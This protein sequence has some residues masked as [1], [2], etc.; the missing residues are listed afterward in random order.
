MFLVLFSSALAGSYSDAYGGTTSKQNLYNSCNVMAWETDV[1][2]VLD[3]IE[4]QLHDNVSYDNESWI[5]AIYLWD[6]SEWQYD[7][8]DVHYRYAPSGFVSSFHRPAMPLSAG[9][10]F[11][12]MVYSGIHDEYS[13]GYTEGFG[14]Y[15]PDWGSAVGAGTSTPSPYCSGNFPRLTS[16]MK[17]AMEIHV[18]VADNDEDGFDQ[19]QDCDDTDPDTYPGA[20]EVWYD[21]IDQGC[22]GG[23]DDDQDGDGVAVDQDCN[24]TDPDIH[25][26]ATETWY[27]GVDSNCDDADDYDQDADGH[28]SDA[29]G[30]DDCDDT[31]ETISPS[32]EEVW[33]DGL[34]QNCNGDN[35]YDQDGDGHKSPVNGGDDCNDKDGAV[36]DECEGVDTDRDG[37][38][39]DSDDGGSGGG[40]GLCGGGNSVVLGLFP[41]LWLLRRRRDAPL[42]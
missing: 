42:D 14:T 35:D 37:W 25:P 29:H 39:W 7:H 19:I 3:S 28:Q 26:G 24:D 36:W 41:L 10:R 12:V 13:I 23:T 17:Y 15:D 5:A 6:G 32:A 11:A 18:T 21:G 9:T 40:S 38:G 20:P 31:D 33:Y 4:F 16:D 8:G 2:I 34:D 27:D 22:D 1:D 30:G